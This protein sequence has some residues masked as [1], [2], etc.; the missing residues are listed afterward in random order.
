MRDKIKINKESQV[1]VEKAQESNLLPYEIHL[2][3]DLEEIHQESKFLALP[4]P[5]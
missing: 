3:K 5:I 4:S 1:K 2:N